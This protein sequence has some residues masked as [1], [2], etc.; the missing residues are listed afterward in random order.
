MGPD[1]VFDD[2]RT[3]YLLDLFDLDT[4]SSGYLVDEN[5]RERIRVDPETGRRVD[6]SR[7]E[8]IRVDELGV[9]KNGS[10]IFVENDLDSLIEYVEGTSSE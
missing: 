10:Q 8:E 3:E 4:D 1:I 2:S 5:S 7:G 6:G 9:I